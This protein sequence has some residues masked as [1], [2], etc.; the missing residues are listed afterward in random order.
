MVVS[1][2]ARARGAWLLIAVPV[3]ACLLT[4]QALAQDAPRNAVES[5]Q[6]AFAAA[7]ADVVQL[8]TLVSTLHDE[9]IAL[10][11]ERASLSA[12]QQHL[13]EQGQSAEAL[14][15]HYLVQAYITGNSIQLDETPLNPSSSGDSLYRAY[16]VQD[17]SGRTRAVAHDLVE[18][19]R[20]TDGH[21]LELIQ[22]FDRN[23]RETEQ[24]EHDLNLAQ[25]RWQIAELQL[26][27]ADH[28]AELATLVGLDTSA[29]GFVASGSDGGP[30]PEQS[31]NAAGIGWARLRQCEAGGNY[32]AVS[33]SGQYRGAYQFDIT[34][35]RGMGG[36]GDPATAPPAEQDYR[37]Q[38]LYNQR[39]AQPWP[40]CGQHL[41]AD[42]ALHPVPAVPPPPGLPARP[43]TAVPPVPTP[44]AVPVPPPPTTVPTTSAPPA[45]PPP[46]AAPTTTTTTAPPPTSTSTSTTTTTAPP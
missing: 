19:R 14:A 34:T 45:T 15:R 9:R 17:H 42:P 32:G 23:T 5:A 20:H 1:N 41:R 39:G 22:A 37:A 7:G 11:V 31:G 40:V 6:A 12:E 13:A 16:L 18:S 4:S 30:T 2:R 29:P 26:R 46:T 21:V 33:P 43:A 24:A 35:W 3:L 27:A 44:V 10:E 38:L 28:D 8:T 36:A 25:Q